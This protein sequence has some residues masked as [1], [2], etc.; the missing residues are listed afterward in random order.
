MPRA[1]P[2]SSTAIS[3]R[4]WINFSRTISP[5]TAYDAFVAVTTT[6]R[7]NYDFSLAQLRLVVVI[8]R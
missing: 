6:I 3:A 4:V 5:A 7:L 8:T 2:A 1:A